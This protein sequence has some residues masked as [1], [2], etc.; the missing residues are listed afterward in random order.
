M[1]P[2]PYLGCIGCNASM[3][4]DEELS[5]KKL[6]FVMRVDRWLETDLMI[7]MGIITVNGKVASPSTYNISSI[8]SNTT[9][10]A[11][12][13]VVKDIAKTVSL[14]QL[15]CVIPRSGSWYRI[16]CLLL[17]VSTVCYKL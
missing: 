11:F 9:S 8:Y 3:L 6:I 16:N 12:P 13:C 4:N 14:P 2:G 1:V 10:Y 7:L 15:L 17:P 5:I